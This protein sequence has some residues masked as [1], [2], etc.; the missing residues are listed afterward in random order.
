MDASLR[1]ATKTP[2]KDATEVLATIPIK[3]IFD[4]LNSATTIEQF[5]DVKQ[6][7]EN[8]MQRW[9]SPGKNG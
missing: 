4:V 1:V 2:R 6:P 5:Y 9:K 8:D 7:I 3:N